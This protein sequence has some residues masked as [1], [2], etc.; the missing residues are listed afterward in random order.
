MTSHIRI[1]NQTAFSAPGTMEPLEFAVE[2]G[3][4]AFEWFV[5]KKFGADG[6]PAGWDEADMDQQQRDVIRR[7]GESHDIL[8]TVH[9]PWQANPLHSRAER[10]LK[11]SVDFARDIGADLVNLHLYMD[12]GAQA[13]VEALA[14]VI[15]Y[16]ADS[17]VRLS[18]ENT[19]LTGP[20]DFN[21][22]FTCLGNLAM[23]TD[24]VGM[25]LDIGHANLF[26]GTRNDYIRY[27]DELAPQIPIIH[28]HVHENWG[29]RDSH[30]TLFT[31]P[32]Q[33]NDAGVRACLERLRK[34]RFRGAMILE[35]W[36]QPPELL[37][38]A[39]RHLKLLLRPTGADRSP[40]AQKKHDGA[41]SG[42][43]PEPHPVTHRDVLRS[44]PQAATSARIA[45]AHDLNPSWRQRLEWI[46]GLISAPEF[47]ASPEQLAALAV[48]LRF[49]GTGE[50]VCEE[51]GR[52]FRPHHHAGAA[53]AIEQRLEA[54]T[55]PEHNWILRKIHPWLPSYG[56][57]FQRSE[58]L[59]RI[60]DIAHRNDIP[61]ALKGEIKHRLQNKLH[62]CAGPEDLETSREILERITAPGTDYASGFIAQFQVFHQE[63][64]EFFNASTLDQR[65]E[66]LIPSMSSGDGARV[67]SFL[68]LKAN[69]E[70]SD[71]Q[72][73][74]LVGQ[75]TGVRERLAGLTL[76]S[77][78]ERAQ[79]MRLADIGL[80]DYAFALLSETVNRLD[81][82]DGKWD[83]RRLLRTFT[84]AVANVRLSHP[85]AAECTALLSELRA[86]T[87]GFD[88]TRHF[89]L[90]RLKA[91]LERI[92]RLAEDYS[93]RILALFPPLV[94]DLG[95]ALGVAEHA[96]RVFCEGDIRGNLVFQLTR[97]TETAQR[98][99]AARLDLPPWAGVAPGESC[100]R[101]VRCTTLDALGP[102]DQAVIILLDSAQ[103]DEEIPSRVRGILL[104]H[105]I[106]HLSH[107]GVRA[108]QARIP[109]AISDERGRSATF[110]AYLNQS[111]RLR[112]AGDDISLEPASPATAPEP[113]GRMRTKT[114]VPPVQLSEET[115]LIP[116]KAARVANCGAKATAAA[117]LRILA[118]Q[119]AGLFRAPRGLILPFGAMQ[120]QLGSDPELD[121]EY[122]SL[123]SAL[124]PDDLEDLD[125]SLNALRRILLGVRL[126]AG[127]TDE[128]RQFFG[129]NTP[130]AVRSS[131]NGEDLENLASAGLYDSRIG[132][133]AAQSADA[134][135]HV[136][137]SLWSRRAVISR[138]QNGIA[139][140]AI[141]MAVLIQELVDPE[142]SF[143]MHT[144]DPVTGDPDQVWVE[145]AVGLGETLA[146]AA[147]PGS[148][149]RI[150]CNRKTG[151][152]S[153]RACASFSLALR[154]APGQGSKAERIDYAR[155]PLS[156]DP[157]AAARLGSRLAEIAVF[158][159]SAFGGPQD[160][161]GIVAG[162]DIHIVQTRPQQGSG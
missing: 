138:T 73:L 94:T 9:A 75:L 104:A 121:D 52:H 160:V 96:I 25:C 93:D 69:R 130:L 102:G 56:R 7:I 116:L 67:R 157:A 122:Q 85:E 92:R 154:P 142:L 80:E 127:L 60:R 47:T 35:Q 126:P 83:W 41:S 149:Y 10:L 118:E 58:P 21:D 50:L 135:R 106:P 95:Q 62:R 159:E 23:D 15:A 68:H 139:H 117:R 51:D 82:E 113:L 156:A 24:H 99:I 111:V 151:E 12:R 78:P 109:F 162:Q 103:G 136:W 98:D 91:T 40:R 37:A 3:F 17:G 110:D 97:L 19:P 66:G 55:V 34:R 155:T 112:V 32:A 28:L 22:T 38:A 65:L 90:L 33:D 128:I 2:R 140:G 132:V 161:E 44:A 49:L 105:T 158:L 13:Y 107:L 46:R 129:A 63:L 81:N 86:W 77:D 14:S 20:A 131:A 147:Q 45:A 148:A 26:S 64:S 30:L 125:D 18:I 6:S 70:R 108:R 88:P 4:K 145:L 8:Y 61:K 133:S 152:A 124:H 48:Y 76:A 150:L 36:P 31:G 39:E 71:A 74:K 43:D 141:H 53:L 54:I 42:E 57:A 16:A 143:I 59:T 89:H 120:H 84:A 114:V 1:G 5:D 87:P 123:Q 134:I 119:S 29:D 144:A 146:S 79:Q 153:L 115:R 27:I 100:G 101:L 72:L 137:A 11:R